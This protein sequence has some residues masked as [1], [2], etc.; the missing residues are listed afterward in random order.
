MFNG[1]FLPRD[2]ALSHCLQFHHNPLLVVLSYLVAA[3]AA[4]T[5][6]DLIE[7]VRNAATVK[8][9]RLWLATA[10]VSMGLGIWAM[11]FIA[12]LA[13]EMPMPIGYDIKVTAVSAGFA[14]LASCVAFSLAGSFRKRPILFLAGL[15]LGG[16][17][18]LMHYVGMTALRMPAHIYYNPWLFVLSAVV[19]VALS[20]A[21]LYAISG[22]PRLMKGRP[23]LSRLIVSAVMGF[24]I[25]LMH[26]TG[27]FATFFY[28]D[29]AA[30]KAGLF[31]NS[32]VMAGAI[33]VI[34]LLIGGLALIAAMF[35]NN[36]KQ[37][38]DFTAALI[39]SLPGFFALLDHAGCF[40]RWNTNLAT[41]TGLSNEQLRGLDARAIA[42][43]K[44]R[45]VLR[46]KIGEVFV[47]GF[48]ALEFGVINQ[49]GE[50][51]AVHWRGRTITYEGRLYL[52]AIGLDM[53]EARAAE[54]RIQ[55]SEDRFRTIFNA[56][57]DGI[58]VYDV[59][60][61]AYIDANPRLC[62]MFGCTREEFLELNLSDL[63]TGVSPY[64]LED[65]APLLKGMGWDETLT[66]EWHCKARDGHN[67]WAEV[68]FRR[69]MFAA[70]AVL[71]ATTRNIT[72]RK[73]T[74]DALRASEVKYRNLFEST[75]DAIMIV[76]P[77]SGRFLSANP[78]TMK[79]FGAKDEEEFISHKPWDYSPESQPDGRESLEK[80]QEMIE[81][82]MRVGS[83]LFEWTHKRVDGTEFSADVL[84]TRVMDG[85]QTLI[86]A[87][88]RDVTERK[89]VEE[90]ITRMARYDILTG[91]ANRGC[92]VDALEQAIARA[93]R[94]ANSFA[95]LYLD[96]DHFKD[97][98]DT[99]GHPVG[100]LLLRAAAERLRTSVRKVDTVARFGGDE[101][102]VIL[103][104]IEDLADAAHVSDRI[105]DAIGHPIFLDELV[106]AA[107]VVAGKIVK[108]VS[109]SFL[110]EGNEIRS[111]ASVGIA[112]YGPD[113]PDAETV[114]SHADVALYRAKSEGRGTY[115]FFTAAMDTEVRA[116]VR[117]SAE[118]REAVTS[119][120]LFL[121]YQP[122]VE[123]DTGRIVGLE[124]LVRWHHPSRG[125]M[126]P[127]RFIPAAERN[128]L[129]VPLGHWVLHEACRQIKRWLDAG[130]AP[131]LI[132]V[133]LS[134]VQF[135]M[136]L[137]LE[138]DIAAILAESGLPARFLE[139]ELTE[140]VLMIA[141]REHNDLLLRLRKLGHRI[142][143]DDFGTGYSSLDYLRRFPVD[144]I[145]IARNF[146]ADIGIVLGD[147]AIVR[148]ALG[149]A[150]E[151]GIEV[152]VEGVESAAQIELLKE[153]GCRIVQGY[154]FARPLP[155]P[156]ITAL[157][158]IGK[159]APANADLVE[160]AAPV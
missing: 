149:L 52:L 112:V 73:R 9:R 31:F 152:V 26:Y 49:S 108:A 25:V 103:T 141:A 19:A 74:E 95:V 132:A 126:W 138:D 78:G 151:L 4:Y 13:V 24:A 94:S 43:E 147:D 124:A 20:T 27:M 58:I 63:L 136:P 41:L 80:A 122:Q 42:V 134:G 128:G 66:F 37:A 18:A 67:F 60:T 86:Y 71:L 54:A 1:W 8:A 154:Y 53:T 57:N 97:V 51:R 76:E 118:L 146:I 148:A 48:A 50:V 156:E 150:R 143:I 96:L 130:I 140:S 121:M 85:E 64:T 56:V 62:N 29:S 30:L 35:E 47:R 155:V 160:I 90:Q 16:G 22:L 131:P 91:L 137:Q 89:R 38:Q 34:A 110:I 119:D 109:E 82:T 11:H 105:L 106:A 116:R 40:T 120:Q 36:R 88:V 61:A 3:F 123:I 115:C 87:T 127:G 5:A 39:D 114:L 45:D 93:R 129:I 117:M 83:H 111:G 17:I 10:S 142:A 14:V 157:L 44:D 100:D 32:S 28:P 92:F 99:L 69:A 81:T 6:F 107:G 21:A 72:E 159:I 2:I 101:F 145:K 68:S 70:R 77:S 139:L 79:L 113:A 65:A 98:N 33:S 158:R 59:G 133:N 144:R 15:V 84:L 153:W 135:K 75:R 125:V 12:I 46:A 7:C 104:D 23:L 55:E 102:A